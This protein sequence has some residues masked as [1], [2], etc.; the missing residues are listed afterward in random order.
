[1][2][3]LLRL[4]LRS[5]RSTFFWSIGFSATAGIANVAIL[6]LIQRLLE[7]QNRPGSAWYVLVCV[8]WLAATSV[9]SMLL[10]QFSEQVILDFRLA[11]SRAVLN[12]PL[13]PL[14]AIGPARI[15][16]T[17][18]EDVIAIG[19]AGAVLPVVI[20]DITVIVTSL[21]YLAWLSPRAL[22]VLG[23]ILS[24][25]L[26]IYHRIRRPAISRMVT[27]RSLQDVLF[28]R[29]RALV[30]ACKEL[31]QSA[32]KRS[33]FYVDLTGTAQAAQVKAVQATN[34][35]N[36][37]LAWG[38]L[39]F[40]FSIAVVIFWSSELGLERAVVTGVVLTVLFVRTPLQSVLNYQPRFAKGAVALDRVQKLGL[41]LGESDPSAPCIDDVREGWKTLE[42]D[43]VTHTYRSED[44]PEVFQLGPI[45]LTLRPGEIVFIVG[46]NGSGKSTLLKLLTGLYLPESGEILFDGVS[47]NDA[48]REWYRQHFSVIFADYYLFE[49]LH[50]ISASK[51]QLESDQLLK[52][53]RLDNK[54]RIENGR[55][56]TVAL[57]TGQRKRLAL[58]SA[59]LEDRPIFV[60]D[61]W[62]SDQDPMFKR[63]FYEDI[64]PRLKAQ[65]KGVV[66]IT[67]DDRY[68]A[69][70]DVVVTLE[71]GQRVRV[72]ETTGEFVRE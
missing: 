65:G 45:K 43:L 59:Y 66:V 68:F 20:T 1:M 70:A 69:S 35:F 53:L 8:G 14:E 56:S 22:G 67:H 4:V 39:L 29:L 61:E 47:I 46:G 13:R 24:T 52:G 36:A 10:V 55:F 17:L 12:S 31:K 6:A 33:D 11:L 60:F 23:L 57:S 62:A 28:A 64:L 21:G 26:L 72:D 34:I 19:D 54:V 7:D 2:L 48:N 15:L 37:A 16:I 40:F 18:T 63:F 50:G 41:S 32:A 5:S 58:V 30:E 25:G 38:Q 9:A 44:S 51:L 3:A 49:Q 71:S 27:L 42:L